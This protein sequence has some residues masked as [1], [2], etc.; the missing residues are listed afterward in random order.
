MGPE[1]H[2]HLVR[3][4]S[5]LATDSADLALLV[6][7]DVRIDQEFL[8]GLPN[9]D[10][11]PFASYVSKLVERL[12]AFG[13]LDRKFFQALVEARPLQREQIAP[14]AAELGFQ[15]GGPRRAVVY[16]V[17][18]SDDQDAAR[19]LASALRTTLSRLLDVTC[20]P[21]TASELPDAVGFDPESYVVHLQHEATGADAQAIATWREAL[22]VRGTV[23][24]RDHD[25]EHLI[26]FLADEFGVVARPRGLVSSPLRDASR[27]ELRL[28]ACRCLD[29]AGLRGFLWDANIDPGCLPVAS[30]HEQVVEL[31]HVIG[32]DGIVDQLGDFLWEERRR[33]VETQLKQLRGETLRA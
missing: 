28:I 29:T 1:Q 22:A 21:M 4:L 32:R 6:R 16:I 25:P 26:K 15:P 14:I 33:C 27:R 11:C 18:G 13:M 20:R 12:G 5:M 24:L 8:H 23:V 10:N 19:A 3:L 31:L 7:H 2:L 30:L 9:A 17:H